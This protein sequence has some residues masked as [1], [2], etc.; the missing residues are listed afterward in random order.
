MKNNKFITIFVLFSILFITSNIARAD[1]YHHSEPI[2]ETIINETIV[3]NAY[4]SKEGIALSLGFAA[5]D[6]NMSSDKWHGGVAAGFY[7]GE[8]APVIG[9]CKR[10]GE[11]L[12]KGSVGV[13]K[14]NYGGNIGI[15]FNF[16]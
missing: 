11:T 3:N 5:I 4:T 13:E 10:F 6:C 2:I 8:T 15:M 16:D 12:I 7:S 1:K 9:I 14:G